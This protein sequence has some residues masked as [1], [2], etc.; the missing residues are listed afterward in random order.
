[1]GHYSVV[2]SAVPSGLGCA[3]VRERVNESEREQVVNCPINA[4]PA[5]NELS[6][7]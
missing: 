6:V 4:I 5:K 7:A 2:I 3:V 1:V